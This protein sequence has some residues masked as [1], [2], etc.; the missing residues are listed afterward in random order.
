MKSLKQKNRT[1]DLSLWVVTMATFSVPS[2]GS[3]NC[4]SALHQALPGVALSSAFVNGEIQSVGTAGDPSRL[5]DRNG[6]LRPLR[7]TEI[8]SRYIFLVNENRDVALLSRDQKK[9]QEGFIVRD[10]QRV[11]AKSGP[12][13]RVEDSHGN[14]FVSVYDI[15]R[16][17]YYPW[18]RFKF[19]DHNLSDHPE[20]ISVSSEHR[21]LVFS[22]ADMV[23]SFYTSQRFDKLIDLR[24]Q[25]GGEIKVIYS[26]EYYGL[27]IKL[28]DGRNVFEVFTRDG[29]RFLATETSAGS[30]KFG[31][32]EQVP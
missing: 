18:R 21:D 15:Y 11:G 19:S 6:I 30:Q 1:L 9:P 8:H 27:G 7:E 14:R 5:V 4:L 22:F 32:F 16:K 13:I 12:N 10:I 17:K 23:F 3:E 28:S 20:L 29:E 26:V 2:L 31:R 25:A 24:V